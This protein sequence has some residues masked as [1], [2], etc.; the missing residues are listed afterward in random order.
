MK[1]HFKNGGSGKNGG[2]GF[3]PAIDGTLAAG[4]GKIN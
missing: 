3:F 2:Y 4:T 1:Y